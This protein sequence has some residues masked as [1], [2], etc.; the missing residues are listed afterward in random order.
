MQLSAAERGRSRCLEARRGW[1]WEQ[2]LKAGMRQEDMELPRK[3]ECPRH[4]L[5]CT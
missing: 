3:G 1:K 5:P 4:G 2:D